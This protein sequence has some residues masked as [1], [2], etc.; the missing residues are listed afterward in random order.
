MY[1]IID[2]GHPA[3]R[4]VTCVLT[5]PDGPCIP[6]REVD[7]DHPELLQLCEQNPGVPLGL[8]FDG[9]I[10][11][12]ATDYALAERRFAE[13]PSPWVVRWAHLLEGPVLDLACGRGRHSRYLAERGLSVLSVDRDPPPGGLRLDLEAGDLGPLQDQRFGAIVVTNYLHRPL[14]PWLAR[15]LLPGGILLYETFMRGQEACGKPTNPDFLLEPGELLTAFPYE[16]LAYEEQ[17]DA[18]PIQQRLCARAA[19]RIDEMLGP[20]L[21]ERIR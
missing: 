12:T 19:G 8:T 9:G 1:A 17:R 11:V 3:W 4:T 7:L 6:W 10:A 14:F 16:V 21:A 20:R 2:Q 15:G 13:L 18:P 5:P